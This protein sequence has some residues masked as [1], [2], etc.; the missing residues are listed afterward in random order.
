MMTKYI[1][2]FI[3][4]LDAV[5]STFWLSEGKVVPAVALAFAAIFCLALAIM[6]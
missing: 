4:G 5:A 6:E 1:I 3:A 2:L